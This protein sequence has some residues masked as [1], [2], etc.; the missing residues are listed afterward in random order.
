TLNVSGAG[1]TRLLN[2]ATGTSANSIT[3]TVN[4][5][6][7]NLQVF[8]PATDATVQGSNSLGTA[9]VTLTGTNPL[10]RITPALGTALTGGTTAG[11]QDKS[12]AGPATYAATNFLG[13]VSAVGG[14]NGPNPTG[15]QTTA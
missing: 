3:G 4:V 2:V 9:A 14:T 10:L 15:L 7:G 5:N 13:A 8:A 11:L 12:F 1:T 6:G